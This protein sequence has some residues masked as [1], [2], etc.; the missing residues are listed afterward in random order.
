MVTPGKLAQGDTL[1]P[2]NPRTTT[3]AARPYTQPTRAST[4]QAM[5]TQAATISPIRAQRSASASTS[6]PGGLIYGPPRRFRTMQRSKDESKRPRQ[7]LPSGDERSRAILALLRCL[8][9]LDRPY[10]LRRRVRRRARI[11]R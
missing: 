3:A 5:L 8:G 2:P 7:L 1:S 6:R 9:F 11:D 10:Q 4:R